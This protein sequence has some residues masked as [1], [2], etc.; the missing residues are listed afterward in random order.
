MPSAADRNLLFGILALQMDFITRDQLVAGMNAWVIDKSL[1]LGAV[2]V[3]QGALSQDNHDLLAPL[4]AAH[5]R[6][7]DGDPQKSLAAVSSA[8]S[9][10]REL[11]QIADAEVQASIGHMTAASAKDDEI[12]TRPFV[13]VGASTAAGVRFRVLRPHAKGGLGQVYVAHD[14]ELPREVALKEIQDRFADNVDHRKRFLLEA[15]IT[16]GLEHPGIVP[17]YGL[18]QYADGRPF[19]A[20][21]FIGGDNLGEAIKR[22]HRADGDKQRDAGER[23]L[24]LR[25]LLRRFQDVCNA[26]AYAH[27]RG[28][29]H[30]DLKPGNIMLGKYGETLVVDW[31]LAKTGVGGQQGA[32]GK[33]ASSATTQRYVAPDDSKSG[34]LTEAILQ[35]RTSGSAETVAGSAI[36]TPQYMSPEQAAGRLDLLGPESDVYSLG[37]TLYCL[38]TG[39]TP[40]ED[41]DTGTILKRVQ[42]GDFPRPRQ[43]SSAIPTPLEAICLKAMAGQPKDRYLSPRDLA[44]DIEHWLAEEPVSAWSEPMSVKIGRW[45]KR[46]KPLVSGLAAAVTVAMFAGAVGLF[47]QQS[48][49]NRRATERLLRLQS[50]REAVEQTEKARQEYAGVLRTPGGIFGLLNEPERWRSQIQ[51]AG[52]FLNRAQG[53]MRG[54]DGDYDAELQRQLK[55]L[56]DSLDMDEKERRTAL[57]LEKIRIDRATAIQGR[58]DNATP[59]REYPLAFAEAG[60]PIAN[61]TA[62]TLA[63]RIQS[64][65]IKQQLVA[66]LDDWAL[67]TTFYVPT[68]ELP[69]KLLAVARLA[70]GSTL[71]GDRV[72]QTSV[73]REPATV[74]ELSKTAIEQNQSP[75][76]L[77][78]VARLMGANKLDRENWLR[79]AQERYPTDFWLNYLLGN[80]LLA[81]NP[82]EAAGFYRAALAVR[83][84]NVA[85]YNNLGNA[86]RMQ[87]RWQEAMAAYGKTVILDPRYAGGYLNLGIAHYDQKQWTQAA[88]AFR[89]AIDIEPDLAPAYNNLGNALRDQMLVDEAAAAYRKAIGIDPKY[90][91]AHHNLGLLLQER[92]KYEAAVEAYRRVI[93]LEPH[94]AQAHN[95]LGIALHHRKH[96]ADAVA[97]LREATKLAPKLATGYLNLGVVLR[98]QLLADHRKGGLSDANAYPKFSNIADRKRRFAE[99]TDAFRKAVDNDK[100]LAAAHGG[101]GEVLAWQG[102]FAE[103]AAAHQQAVELLP[104]KHPLRDVNQRY[105]SQCKR[106]LALEQQI[107]VLL[108]NAKSADAATLLEAAQ[109]CQDYK[110][111]YATAVR[112]YRA[113]FTVDPAAGAKLATRH[114]YFAACAAVLAASGRGPEPVKL[115]ADQAALLRQQARDWLRADLDA[116]ALQLKNGKSNSK[117]SVLPEVSSWQMD[118]DL[119]DVRDSKSLERLPADER[120]PWQ[121]LW[122]D[123]KQLLRD[124]S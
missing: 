97:E 19:Y 4:V 21:R 121:R 67:L 54:N 10:R 116:V 99:I 103:A 39:K 18:G 61:E 78:L 106:L 32:A 52:A 90:A 11:E 50:V 87:E 59:A 40:F 107:P 3:K 98:E 110:N 53:L 13:S 102:A 60:L 29:L 70:E 55:E 47:W 75:Q 115:A 1:S 43:I 46:H 24:S 36:G 96:F 17:V 82:L 91:P 100:Q 15:E 88:T 8:D 51:V 119:A 5:I 122:G 73:W 72:R 45:V 7:H 89:K 113:A 124:R 120:E 93:E 56:Q 34:V 114:R 25:K 111:D 95:D 42:Q 44:E 31:G 12:G 35:P 94:N 57:R 14:E 109:L 92:G 33:S 84:T 123:V 41:A 23:S 69:E 104:P 37:A 64:S 83:P 9:A 101:L 30:R 27:S 71:W 66:A 65:P 105:L 26:I 62:E 58:F 117:N 2:L 108:A 38:L 68:K 76:M 77:A 49:Q 112:L 48:E 16:G 118:P 74:M 79:K 80:T 63:Q 6:K 22:F 28:V 81:K 86:L 85:T 20:M